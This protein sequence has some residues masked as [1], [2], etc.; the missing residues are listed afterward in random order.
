MINPYNRAEVSFELRKEIGQDGQNSNAFIAHDPQLGTEIVVKKILKRKINSINDFFNESRVL[1]LSG[2]PN[3]VQIYYACQDVENIYIA[4]PYYKNGSLK[5]LIDSRFLTVREIIIF[6]CQ[7]ASGLH[8]VHSK[9]LIHF[10]IKPDNIL[11]S[12]RNEALISDFG[13]AKPTDF[14]GK[15]S[16]DRLYSKMIPPETITGEEFTAL[17]DIYQLGLTLYRMCNGN[18]NFDQQFQKYGVSF[19]SFDRDAFRYD[20]RNG[21]FPDRKAFL[22]HIPDKL[23]RVINKCLEPDPKN[24]YCATIE[25]TNALADIDDN[26][27]D[28]QFSITSSGKMWEKS[29]EG[30]IYKLSISDDGTSLAEK[31]VGSGKKSKIREYCKQALTPK[32]IKKFLGDY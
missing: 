4:M 12:D 30:K 16:Q 6:G 29:S 32:E 25:V 23:R 31:T 10:D 5:S 21:K 26:F 14:S 9:K 28:W 2:H 13:L 19:S 1:Y 7:M 18:L 24:R 3:V 27:L 17:F 15:A 11:L 22:D 8:N 20:L